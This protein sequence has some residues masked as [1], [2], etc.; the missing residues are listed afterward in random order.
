MGSVEE[1]RKLCEANLL[2]EI[3]D[4]KNAKAFKAFVDLIL[5]GI[6]RKLYFR[7]KKCGKPLSTYIT[8]ADEA[9]GLLILENNFL[10]WEA[11]V[12]IEVGMDQETEARQ[13]AKNCKTK[14]AVG[15]K[16]SAWASDQNA[17]RSYNAFVE[18]VSENRK[19]TEE[20]EL[21]TDIMNEYASGNTRKSTRGLKRKFYDADDNTEESHGEPLPL[22]KPVDLFQV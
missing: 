6:V 22:L 19:K 4:I 20:Q 21:E 13:A 2:L 1:L 18:M 9:F 11:Y 16:S 5:P 3:R 8:V 15:G 7:N 17:I 10:K 12:R 14:Y